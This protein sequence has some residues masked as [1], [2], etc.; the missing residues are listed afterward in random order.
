[1]SHPSNQTKDM[2]N[3]SLLILQKNKKN[4]G[5]PSPSTKKD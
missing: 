3:P 4:Y 2:I 5:H 1:L